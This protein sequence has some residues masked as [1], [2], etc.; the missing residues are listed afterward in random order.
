M[1]VILATIT[2]GLAQNATP[3]KVRLV[4]GNGEWEMDSYSIYLSFLCL[5]KFY[6]NRNEIKS[7]SGGNKLLHLSRILIHHT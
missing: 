3:V 2:W 6:K 5:G 1:H 7:D 4:R